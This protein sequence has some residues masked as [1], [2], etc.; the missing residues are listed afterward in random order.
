MKRATLDPFPSKGWNRLKGKRTNPR[1]RTSKKGTV[2]KKEGK[3]GRRT[4]RVE[5]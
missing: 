3:E 4:V 2:S 1:L 5:D